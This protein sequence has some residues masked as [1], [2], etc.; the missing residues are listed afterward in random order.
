MK[1]HDLSVGQRLFAGA[2]AV[3]VLIAMLGIALTVS[4]TRSGR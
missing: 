4:V 3:A 2:T 1:R